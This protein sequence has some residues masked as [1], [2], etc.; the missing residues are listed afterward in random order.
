MHDSMKNHIAIN[1]TLQFSKKNY[2]KHKKK[3]VFFKIY[4][5]VK[6]IYR[7]KRNQNYFRLKI[8]INCLFTL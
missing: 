8:A 1:K 4:K 5:K 7:M 6:Q 3:K 2:L